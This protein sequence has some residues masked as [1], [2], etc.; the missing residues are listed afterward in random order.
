V[1]TR[2]ATIYLRKEK[3]YVHSN[4]TTEAG[5]WIISDPMQVFEKRDTLSIGE[6]VQVAL[7][8][9]RSRV[10]TPPP[11]AEIFTPMLNLAGAKSWGDFAKSAKCVRV[12]MEGGQLVAEPQR[13]MGP[14]N[15]FDPMP[16]KRRTLPADADKLGEAVMAALADAQ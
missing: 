6:A 4:S 12:E 9:C 2:M 5:F 14:R 1:I 7:K 11:S 16:E 15:G 8:A 10:S 3:V 13:N